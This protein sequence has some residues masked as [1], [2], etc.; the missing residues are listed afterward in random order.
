MAHNGTFKPQVCQQTVNTIFSAPDSTEKADQPRTRPPIRPAPRSAYGR[1]SGEKDTAEPRAGP[2]RPK[3]QPYPRR[4]FLAAENASHGKRGDQPTADRARAWAEKSPSLLPRVQW[5][6]HRHPRLVQDMGINH[7]RL[8]RRMAQQFLNRPDVMP[9]LQQMRRK[10]MSQRVR[11]HP[12]RD[13]RPLRCLA[14]RRLECRILHMVSPANPRT[15]IH[16]HLAR[17]K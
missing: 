8:H 16:G 9:S 5:A 10:T 7:R 4:R 6:P 3:T 13:F 1:P 14:N 17:R 15:G 12:F 11:R 2:T